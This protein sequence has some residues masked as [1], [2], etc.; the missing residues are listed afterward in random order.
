MNLLRTAR[1]FTALGVGIFQILIALLIYSTVR[2]LSLDRYR[3]LAW[4]MCLAD[5][6]HA[7]AKRNYDRLKTLR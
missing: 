1:Y 6:L 4:L 7:R 5:W 2:C 3:W